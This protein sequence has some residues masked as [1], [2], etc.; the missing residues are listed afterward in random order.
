MLG[1]WIWET[2][3]PFVLRVV[4]VAGLAGWNL[5]IFPKPWR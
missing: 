4:L 1:L 2:S 3:W 5:L